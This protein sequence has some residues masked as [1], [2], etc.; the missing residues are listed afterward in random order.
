MDQNASMINWA[1][2]SLV[3]E[4]P[5]YPYELAQRYH[6]RYGEFAPSS[7]PNVYQTLKRLQRHGL[8]EPLLGPPSAQPSGQPKINYRATA[9]GAAELRAWVGARIRREGPHGDVLGRIAAVGMILPGA[10]G[11]VLDR[12]EDE[13]VEEALR[14]PL[15]PPGREQEPRGLE[16]LLELMMLEHRR[17][18]LEAQLTWAD[19][20]R[21]RLRAFLARRGA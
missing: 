1:V 11:E 5:S 18:V 16:Q 12:F 9:E 21:E 17:L 13:C 10:I 14:L 6:R 7:T 3:I 8:V 4:R 2:L 15:D 20:A 19:A